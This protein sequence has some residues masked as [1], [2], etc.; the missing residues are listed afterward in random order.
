MDILYSPVLFSC[1][2][3]GLF[4]C[5]RNAANYGIVL[6]C[7][8]GFLH[9]TAGACM[10]AGV[11]YS[12]SGVSGGHRVRPERDGRRQNI[13]SLYI[14]IILW[15][16]WLWLSGKISPLSVRSGW[17]V[18]TQIT[19]KYRHWSLSCYFWLFLSI[20]LVCSVWWSVF[21]F[22]YLPVWSGL[23]WSD[24]RYSPV[25]SWLVWSSGGQT[26]TCVCRVYQYNLVCPF[27]SCP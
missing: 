6:C 19:C 27:L 13:P 9:H 20:C 22:S 2:W 15:C 4:T 21:Y 1:L 17:P 24:Y 12:S 14:F 8:R 11:F 23:V 16:T 7:L 3:G 26:C 25:L 18:L 5:S 10:R